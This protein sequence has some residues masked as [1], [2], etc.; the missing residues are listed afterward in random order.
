MA[1]RE[2]RVS[3]SKRSLGISATTTRKWVFL[4]SGQ[5]VMENLCEGPN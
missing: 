4:L 1:A 2:I 5:E 3:V